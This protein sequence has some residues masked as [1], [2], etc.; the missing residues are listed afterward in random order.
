MKV[1]LEKKRE[2]S[3]RKMMLNSS[4]STGILAYT[5][6]IMLQFNA[7][8]YFCCLGEYIPV[9]AQLQLTE[10]YDIWGKLCNKVLTINFC[11]I[12]STMLDAGITMDL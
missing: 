10:N 1:H 3:R 9:M 8:T 6:K 4:R 7:R 11:S 12:L 5:S 2:S